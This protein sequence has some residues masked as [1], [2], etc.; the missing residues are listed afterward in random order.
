M[1]YLL[2]TVSISFLVFIS[3][4][5]DDESEAKGKNEAIDGEE[6]A[7]ILK[8]DEKLAPEKRLEKHI[9]NLCDLLEKDIDEEDAEGFVDTYMGYFEDNGADLIYLYADLI[10][11]VMYEKSARSRTERV[12][13]IAHYLFDVVEDKEDFIQKMT[14][15]ER[16]MNRVGREFEDRFDFGRGP[17]A[18]KEFF[19]QYFDMEELEDLGREL[20]KRAENL[21]EIFEGPRRSS[22]DYYYPEEEQPDYYYSDKDEPEYYD[23]LNDQDYQNFCAHFELDRY[24]DTCDCIIDIIYYSYGYD[25]RAFEALVKDS[26][27]SEY[28]FSVLK[29]MS[30]DMVTCY[31]RESDDAGD[32]RS[33]W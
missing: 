6:R 24:S 15:N 33:G 20:S 22:Y 30:R 26:E 16:F 31:Y 28:N 21:G 8:N 2:I 29:N 11:D 5:K 32:D 25:F 1:K 17:R 23:A 13:D 10:V 7:E 27:Y 18:A 4:S 3:C 9:D 12:S 14:D 19:G